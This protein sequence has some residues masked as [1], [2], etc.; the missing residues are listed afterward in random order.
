MIEKGV[1]AILKKAYVEITNVCNLSCGFCR[2][3]ARPPRF[4]PPE[5]FAVIAGKLRP[6]T[7]Y[8]Y[9]HLL[10]EPLLHP[11]LKEILSICKGLGFKV[12][13]VTNGLLLDAAAGTLN[14]CGCLYKICYSLHAYEA[15]A[16]RISAE[17]YLYPIVRFAVPS[18]KNGVINVFKLWN[19]GG[20]NTLNDLMINILCAHLGAS[21]VPAR[22]GFALGERMYLDL[23]DRFGWPDLAAD[24]TPPRFCMALRDQLG[25]L[26]DGTAVPCCLDADGTLRLGNLLTDSVEDVLSA[27][28]ALEIKNGFSEGKAVTPLCR[29]CDF[30]KRRFG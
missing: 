28:L 10:G 14:E 25:V 5:E 27:P 16:M 30:A 13:I 19:G 22:N 17:Q 18:A 29:R 20:E 21:P 11:Q 3:T 2:G 15:N 12:T 1:S 4:L 9:L 7:E 23:A 6:Y 24:E 26:C 8:I